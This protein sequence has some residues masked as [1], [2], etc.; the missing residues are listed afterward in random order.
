MVEV[1]ISYHGRDRSEGKKLSRRDWVG[2][3]WTRLKYRVVS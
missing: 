3:V 1:P 2:V